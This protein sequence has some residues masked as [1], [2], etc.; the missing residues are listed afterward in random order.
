MLLSVSIT[1]SHILKFLAATVKKEKETGETDFNDLFYLAYVF[2]IS[3][4]VISTN[5]NGLFN[6]ASLS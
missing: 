4:H 5:I 6:R 2:K 1:R 3:Q